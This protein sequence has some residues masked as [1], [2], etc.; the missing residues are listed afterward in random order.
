M[1]ESGEYGQAG[2]EERREHEEYSQAQSQER[3]R[4]GYA[5]TETLKLSERP[6]TIRLAAGE[7]MSLYEDIRY[8]TENYRSRFNLGRI[9]DE[10]SD[11]GRALSLSHQ[12]L[13]D[14][15]V[16]TKIYEDQTGEVEV[17]GFALGERRKKEEK[18]VGYSK[19]K[20]G[21]IIR[22]DW[23]VIE[24]IVPYI[25]TEQ[26]RGE[27]RE[28]L[29]DAEVEII[30]AGVLHDAY[31]FH[32]KNSENLAGLGETYLH[33]LL[34]G[35]ALEKFF[36]SPAVWPEGEV[37]TGGGVEL[38]S[39]GEMYDTALRVWEVVI[40]LS[41]KPNELQ[42]FRERPGWQ[43]LFPG[44]TKDTITNE[45]R[46]WVG[47]VSKWHR[48]Y[49][50]DEKGKIE[51]V[52]ESNSKGFRKPIFDKDYE[53]ELRERRKKLKEGGD[54]ERKRSPEEELREIEEELREIEEERE[55]PRGLLTNFGNIIAHTH[56]Y[57]QP[58]KLE[59]LR[60][61]I[62]RF[63][64][65][66]EGSTP[67]L[68]R[69][70]K[71][72]EERA[73]RLSRTWGS[74]DGRG[75]E[76]Y[77]TRKNGKPEYKLQMDMGPGIGSDYLKIMK[78]TLYRW[79]NAARRR[80]AGAV[81]TRARYKS[82]MEP[83]T[84]TLSYKSDIEGH[85][86]PKQR[87]IEELL[88]GYSKQE[89]QEGK[90]ELPK[91]PAHRYGE[92]E[93]R[94]FGNYAESN[95]FLRPFMIAREKVGV[96]DLTRKADW[97]AKELYDMTNHDWWEQYMKRIQVGLTSSV[98]AKGAFRGK[99]ESEI[100]DEKKR[101]WNGIIVGTW[102]GVRSSKLY[103][104]LQEEGYKEAIPGTTFVISRSTIGEIRKV[105]EDMMGI[106]L[107]TSVLPL[108]ERQTVKDFWKEDIEEYIYPYS[109]YVEIKQAF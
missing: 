95:F 38:K 41:E 30:V 5:F 100:E 58:E 69:I 99:N 44:S 24:T 2:D 34:T 63:L 18:R 54:T 93:W 92:I 46:K 86:Y 4:K 20:G 103:R 73:F 55:E 39:V 91:E 71:R 23:R 67:Q 16:V 29:E 56:G 98:I 3:Y 45:E 109:N 105:V 101:L 9:V 17:P 42:S 47:D 97:T 104:S 27:N 49:R 68:K 82:F 22:E 102:D 21:N 70:V 83:L 80:D 64:G 43:Y 53:N 37:R 25:G 6:N 74:A 52:R 84:R 78:P 96:Y 31:V 51:E 77:L 108:E 72:A 61:E 60:E 19:D 35:E 85:D 106:K 11:R 32:D 81:Y 33:H 8:S 28:A 87:T 66:G 10:I 89:K 48:G 36:N 94:K 65:G 14:W 7:F 15:E 88:W 79:K 62:R 90:P 57:L 1:A 107:D 40:G 75:W 12:E 26:E 76:I 50:V 13:Q 59:E